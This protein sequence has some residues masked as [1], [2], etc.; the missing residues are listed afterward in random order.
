MGKLVGE[1]CRAGC[2][3]SD[4]TA[5]FRLGSEI[6]RID[7]LAFSHR[8]AMVQFV[9]GVRTGNFAT[10][11]T[12]SDRYSVIVSGIDLALAAEALALT[13]VMGRIGI[14]KHGGLGPDT[15][16][17]GIA[18]HEVRHRLQ[19]HLCGDL[20]LWTFRDGTDEST[21]Q[22]ARAVEFQFYIRHCIAPELV[23]ETDL[24]WREPA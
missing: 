12:K 7:A 6:A 21:E 19:R 13:T 2:D 22:D 3:L 5:A 4:I 20:R 1:L 16:I 11:G 24:L 23:D 18:L 9:G 10:Y 14:L 17:R 15:I 8:P